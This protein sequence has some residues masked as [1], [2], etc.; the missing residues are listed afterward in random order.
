MSPSLTTQFQRAV[1]AL[2]LLAVGVAAA[3]G[4]GSLPAASPAHADLVAFA[5]VQGAASTLPGDNLELVTGTAPA[6]DCDAE[7]AGARGLARMPG[8]IGTLASRLRCA[9]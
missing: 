3:F 8:D 1:F 6:L 7:P 5:P 4:A 9:Q 2:P